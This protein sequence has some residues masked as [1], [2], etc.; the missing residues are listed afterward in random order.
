M[1]VC[2]HVSGS[3]F[4]CLVEFAC[5]CV[6]LRLFLFVL[7]FLVR[8]RIHYKF[9]DVSRLWRVFASFFVCF[10]L[11]VCLELQVFFVICVFAYV[12]VFS[13]VCV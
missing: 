11:C 4:L 2:L 10:F 3:V 8:F 7:S 6:C 13:C 5:I 9:A 1:F 12:C